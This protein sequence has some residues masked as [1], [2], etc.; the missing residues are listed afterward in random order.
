MSPTSG[1]PTQAVSA[2]LFNGDRVL[3][4]ERSNPP[5]KGLWSLPGGKV[6][7]GEELLDAIKRELMEETNLVA[8]QLHFV[9]TLNFDVPRHE[10]HVFAGYA[11][12]DHA[13]ALDDADATAVIRVQDLGNCHTTPNLDVS[14]QAA[15]ESLNLLK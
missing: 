3:L 5:F 6:E 10:L 4:V 11:D 15:W 12:I 9:H 8:E 1:E 14:V 13:V 2:A 7:P